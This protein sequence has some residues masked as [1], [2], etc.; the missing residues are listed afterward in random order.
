MQENI[1]VWGQPGLWRGFQDIQEY[2]EKHC[3][4]I[5]SKQ[6]Y[7]NATKLLSDAKLQEP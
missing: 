2:T 5:Q 7:K 3:L 4:K 1:W 6:T